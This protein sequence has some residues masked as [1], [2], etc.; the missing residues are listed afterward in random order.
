M[1]GAKITQNQWEIN[2][3]SSSSSNGHDLMALDGNHDHGGFP[4]R[5]FCDAQVQQQSN[6][7]VTTTTTDG[8]LGVGERVVSAAGA[9][10]LSAII[11][12]PLDV[13]KVIICV[14]LLIF[15]WVSGYFFQFRLFWLCQYCLTFFY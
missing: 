2:S 13:V 4:E 5:R 9:A 10:F 14:F 3:D 11:V 12:N 7:A 8:S 15:L 1:M 6:S